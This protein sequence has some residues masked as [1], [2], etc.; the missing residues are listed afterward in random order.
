MNA[1][2]MNDNDGEEIINLLKA[3]HNGI[4]KH[5]IKKIV[6]SLNCLDIGYSDGINYES[7]NYITST[8]CKTL[9]VEPYLLYGFESRGNVTI[10]RKLC[11]LLF[12]K[13][14]S[15]SAV[16]SALHFNRSRQI[17]HNAEN[18]FGSMSEKN[19]QHKI[20]L[21]IY[22]DLDEKIS[23]FMLKIPKNKEDG[24]Q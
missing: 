2:K 20:F 9:K 21:E 23:E 18:E 17:A 7:L 15:L 14:L 13:H 3:I 11:L 10:A 4:K 6:K 1:L 16:E 5:G 8:V 22:K 19:K 24:N 12:R